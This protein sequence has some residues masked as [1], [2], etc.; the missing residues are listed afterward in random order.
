M[1]F[2]GIEHTR[3]QVFDKFSGRKAFSRRLFNF[4][5]VFLPKTG[6]VL[7][8]ITKNQG[9]MMILQ[10]IQV[11]EISALGIFFVFLHALG[12]FWKK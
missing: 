2:N 8:D 9:K 5:R 1:Y 3:G 10:G 11:R 6:R 12:V 4:W 7:C